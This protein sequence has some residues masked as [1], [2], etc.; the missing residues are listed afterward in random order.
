[1]VQQESEF[2]KFLDVNDENQWYDGTKWRNEN[3]DTVSGCIK[4]FY[5]K[6]EIGKDHEEANCNVD[7]CFKCPRCYKKHFIPDN[8]DYLC[9]GCCRALLTH[10]KAHEEWIIGIKYWRSI[11]G[12]LD[13]P[14]VKAR[15]DERDTLSSC[16]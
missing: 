2:P 5:I 4:S 10:P 15:Y 3:D 12:R 8:Y 1:M 13:L 9:D 14:E 11:A 7:G 16:I 6:S